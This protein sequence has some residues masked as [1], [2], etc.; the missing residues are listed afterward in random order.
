ML[1]Q[2]PNNLPPYMGPTC[3]ILFSS[4]FSFSPARPSSSHASRLLESWWRSRIGGGSR[5]PRLLVPGIGRR[6]SA[7]PAARTRHRQ[8]AP[9]LL[10]VA[11]VEVS[12]RL[13][14]RSTVGGYGRLQRTL[15]SHQ[16]RLPAESLLPAASAAC[17]REQCEARRDRAQRLR[18]CTASSPSPSARARRGTVDRGERDGGHGC[19]DGCVKLPARQFCGEGA[20]PLS[21]RGGG[22]VLRGMRKIHIG[23]RIG[24]LLEHVNPSN[25]GFFSLGVWIGRLLEML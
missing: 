24:G 10:V 1:Q 11:G 2:K 9:R 15:A 22:V 14:P 18:P 16:R 7:P 8:K 21:L 19:G 17:P 23:D 6:I 3:Q 12:G 20:I 13:L 25:F 5:R 4:F